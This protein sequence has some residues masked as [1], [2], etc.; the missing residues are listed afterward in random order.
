MVQGVKQSLLQKLR[1]NLV[2]CISCLCVCFNRLKRLSM[3]ITG[4]MPALSWLTHFSRRNKRTVSSGGCVPTPLWS[5]IWSCLPL[6]W[7][8][9]C[10]VLVTFV[11]THWLWLHNVECGEDNWTIASSL[12]ILNLPGFNIKIEGL[13][14]SLDSP[15]PAETNYSMVCLPCHMAD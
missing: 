15:L 4:T 8:S 2:L 12:F 13:L 10:W 7:S 9:S 6:L 3:F 14:A 11:Q 5:D 1:L